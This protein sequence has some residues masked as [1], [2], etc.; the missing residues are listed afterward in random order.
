MRTLN[1]LQKKSSEKTGIENFVDCS[2]KNNDMKSILGGGGP[3][4]IILW[5]VDDDEE[6]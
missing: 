5:W 1:F 3:D 4:P 6:K 2:L